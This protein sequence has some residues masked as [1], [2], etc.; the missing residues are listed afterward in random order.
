MTVRRVSVGNRELRG[1][2][3][4]YASSDLDA[5]WSVQ[6]AD[7]GLVLNRRRGDPIRLDRPF[8]DAFR[9][10]GVFVRFRRDA[11]GKVVA[12]EVSA[13]ERARHIRFDRER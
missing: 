6:V 11:R 8:E 9:N 12:M 3:G 7:S 1:Y 10:P 13:G 4:S 2:E 5:R